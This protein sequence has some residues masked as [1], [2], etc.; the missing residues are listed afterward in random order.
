VN[1][2][3]LVGDATLLTGDCRRIIPD[4]STNSVDCIVT[5]PPYFGLRDYGTENQI[6]L[7]ASPDEYVANL[8]YT[9]RLLWRVLRVDGTVWLNL[10][11]SYA[12]SGKG[13]NADGTHQEGGKQGTH[14]GTIEGSLSKSG[15]YG[16]KQKDLIGIPW[17]VALAL[18]TDGWYLRQDIIWSKPNPMPESVQDRCTKAHEY[19]FL[20]SK[21]PRYYFDNDAIREPCSPENIKDFLGRKATKNKGGGD[22]SYESERP[23]LCRDRADYMSDDLSRNRRS[24]WT[25]NTR[26]YPKAHF[27][28]F[29]P[30]LIEP[31]VLAGCRPDGVVLDPFSGSGT[32]GQVALQQGRKYI[33][34]ELNPDYQRLAVE[35]ITPH[36]AQPRL[37]V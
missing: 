15:T 2:E 31:C 1:P 27:A 20:L 14:R 29:P 16:L 21:S 30:E 37:F 3:I 33:G 10:G 5:S 7:E 36:A 22:M 9:F 25:V 18:Q 24:V 12:G 4:M 32:T 28:T 17:R 11:D 8:V 34:I 13:R 6:G 35:R 23:D 19:V 26:P